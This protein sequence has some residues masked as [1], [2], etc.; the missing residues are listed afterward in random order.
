MAQQNERNHPS[1]THSLNTSL[2]L[3]TNI[4]LIWKSLKFKTS[5]LH[6]WRIR[7]TLPCHLPDSGEGR[8]FN[9]K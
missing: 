4:Y 1:P 3:I 7:L 6:T 5:T 8:F 9:N 2:Y